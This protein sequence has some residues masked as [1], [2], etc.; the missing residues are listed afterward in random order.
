VLDQINSQIDQLTHG[1]SWVIQIFV[2]VFCTLLV[3]Y[4]QKRALRRVHAR[5]EKTR[6]PW[7]DAVVNALQSPASVLV[8][9]VGLSFG[10]AIVEHK[11]DA[12]IFSA[13]G[14]I[15]NAG[16]IVVIAWFLLR[17][18]NN[19]QANFIQHRKELGEEID[20]TTTEAISK[21]LRVSVIITGILVGLQTLGFS[22]SGVLAFGGIGGIAVGFA[23]KDLLSNFFGGLMIYL[24]RPFAVGDWIRS[25]D[26][27]IEGTVEHIGWRQ[28][29]IRTFEA[30][31][32]YVPN[33]V[34]A[35]IAVENPSRMVNRRIKEHVGIRYDDVG[36]MES[37][38]AEIKQMLQQH[39]EIDND[40][41]IIVSFDAFAPSSIDFLV[42]SYTKTTDWVRYHEIKHDVL[43]KISDIIAKHGAEIAFPTS[44]LHLPDVIKLEQQHAAQ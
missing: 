35:N 33:S 31:P 20:H 38:T 9:V 39:P 3:D 14:P 40:R 18:I 26:R 41:V 42:Y 30:R 43:L 28:T 12:P 11:I 36:E 27:E 23:A 1:N 37:I 24:D 44:T 16:V 8:W 19:A 7:D 6:T 22:V 5:L 32:L 2:I 21:L 17:L 29:R 34:F 10:A 13:I 15:R 25:P 4:F